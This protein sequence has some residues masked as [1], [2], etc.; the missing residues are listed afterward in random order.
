MTISTNLIGQSNSAW[1]GNYY[2]KEK[3]SQGRNKNQWSNPYNIKILSIGNQYFIEGIYFQARKKIKIKI[4]G[5]VFNIP[6][7]NLGVGFV[8]TGKGVKDNNL[9]TM[10]YTVV[11]DM[12]SIGK[13]DVIN[14]CTAVFLKGDYVKKWTSKNEEEINRKIQGNMRKEKE[15]QKKLEEERRKKEKENLIKAREL[16]QEGDNL[17]SNKDW[18]K[19][20]D[21]YENAI[22]TD[23]TDSV[24]SECGVKMGKAYL[25]LGDEYLNK[26]DYKLA[27]YNYQKASKFDKTL[28]GFTNEK[29]SKLK[30]N[31]ISN[32]ISSLIPGLGQIRNKNY[33][34]GGILLGLVSST[35][36][37]SYNFKKKGDATYEEYKDA[38]DVDQIIELYDQ[39][40]AYRKKSVLFGTIASLSMIYGLIDAYVIADNYNKSLGIKNIVSIYPSFN[41]ETVTV[42]ISLKF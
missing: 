40:E 36:Y 39:A 11:I 5:N 24:D 28:L 12:S 2:G 4:L 27:I 9:L 30:R 7:Q 32:S 41:G 42:S 16:V 37:L 19:A 38:T 1:L 15:K 33:L 20:I 23:I 31:P 13:E 17:M 35:S 3:C 26:K 29:M 21:K 22:R 18:E 10:D 6:K 25:N 8:I 34:K 14:N